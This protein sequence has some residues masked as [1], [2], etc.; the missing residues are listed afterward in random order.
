MKKPGALRFEVS[1]PLLNA[2]RMGHE[3]LVVDKPRV[4]WWVVCDL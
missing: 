2:Q 3:V 4:T 1:H